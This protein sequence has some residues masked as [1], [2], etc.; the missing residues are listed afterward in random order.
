[1]PYIKQENRPK[2]KTK[3]KDLGQLAD[4][5]GDLN[6][7]ITEM[8]HEYIRK[9]GKNYATINE[10]VGMMECCKLELYRKIAAPYEN[11]K[12][13]ENGDVGL[14]EKIISKAFEEEC[15]CLGLNHLPECPN[16]PQS[17]GE[18]PY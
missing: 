13:V 11:L 18:I 17:H 14:N 6:Y 1:M 15:D 9:K 2:F 5:A 16:S 4:C 3:A 7:I 12:V 8:V 10:V